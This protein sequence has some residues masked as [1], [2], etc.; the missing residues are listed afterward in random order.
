MDWI[1]VA[2]SFM[3]CL[4]ACFKKVLNSYVYL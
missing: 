3:S 4:I 2:S 1:R